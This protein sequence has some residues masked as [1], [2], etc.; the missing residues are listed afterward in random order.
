LSKAQNQTA[1]AKLNSGKRKAPEALLSEAMSGRIQ[2]I[3]AKFGRLKKNFGA[4]EL[5]LII[6]VK[7]WRCNLQ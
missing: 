7:I 1:P 5:K 6:E 2:T 4:I 3:G